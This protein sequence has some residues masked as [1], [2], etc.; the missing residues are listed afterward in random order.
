MFRRMFP[1]TPRLG[2]AP[3]GRCTDG[4]PASLFQESMLDSTIA[5]IA[6]HP[7]W[8]LSSKTSQHQLDGR[9]R[10]PTWVIAQGCFLGNQM[11]RQNMGIQR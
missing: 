2:F 7:P 10:V 9:L 3:R 11:S 1:F 4:V 6:E 8:P 5:T